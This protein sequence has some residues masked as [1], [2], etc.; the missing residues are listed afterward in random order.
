MALNNHKRDDTPIEFPDQKIVSVNMEREVKKSFL[1]Y[2]MSVIVS[3]ALPDA[4]DGMKPGQRRIMY[5]MFEDGLTHDKPFRKSA[6]TVGN[7]LGRYHPHGDA[8]VYGTMVRMAQDFS[9]R[10]PLVQGHGNF[11]SIDGDGAAAYRYTEARMSKISEELMADIGKEVVD[12]VPNFDNSRREPS[13]L[14]TK[15]PNLLVNGSV[16]IAVGMATNIPTHN[17]TEV[18]DGT[19]Y[20]MDHPDAGVR[21]LM[22]FIKGPDFPTKATI[23]GT[24]G[25]YEAY[26]TGRGK[27]MV[28]AKA[29]VDEEKRQIVITEIPYMVNKSE[30][31]KAMASQVRDKKIE[32]VTDI[33]DESGKAGLRIT[34][35]YRKDANGQVILNQFYKYTQLQDTCAINMLALVDGEP[36]ILSLRQI[37]QNYINFRTDVTRRRT[38]FEL[39]RALHEAH[40]NEG[41]KIATDNIDEVITIIRNSP[42]TPTAK[43]RLSERFSLSEEQSQAIVSMTLGRL[44]GLE[45]QKVEERLVELYAIIDEKRAIL[46]DPEKLKGIIK[47]ELIAVRDKYGDER[48]TEIVE[49]HDEIML[50]DLIERHRC[51]ITLTH[52]GYIKRQKADAYAAQSRGGKGRRGI[53]TKEEDY[54]ERVV[55]CESHDF[56]LLFTNLG[57]VYT[58]KPYRIPEASYNAKGSHIVNLLDLNEGESV[59]AMLATDTLTPEEEKNLIMITRRGVIKKTP[60]R[61]YAINRKGGK[62]A[63]NLDEG[64]ELTFVALTDGGRDIMVAANTGLLARF[65]EK[66]VSTVGRTARGVRAMKLEP[67]DRIIGAAVVSSDPEWVEEHKLITLTEKGFGKRMSTALFENKGRAIKG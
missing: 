16:G 9:Y 32:G 67:G 20:L 53:A 52:G 6:T 33:R 15:F 51:V 31:V 38:Q 27:V 3:R 30:L 42:D 28:R 48:L 11:G 34:V 61:E 54:V 13:V 45:R 12:W 56:L 46:S 59:T 66:R 65:S 24:S 10:Y 22:E 37:L 40:I 8:A 5:A 7:V 14:P 36:R 47:D 58:T 60:L 44:S 62:I 29:E 50:E 41:Y 63:I 25:I 39:D 57:R 17:L 64:D 2:S 26:A 43:I 21:E 18:I 1:E 35:D 49:Y 19:V 4:R 23:F 55:A